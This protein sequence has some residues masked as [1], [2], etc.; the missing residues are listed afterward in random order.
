MADFFDTPYGDSGCWGRDSFRG[1]S[2][3]SGSP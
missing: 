2:D 1:S 3:T